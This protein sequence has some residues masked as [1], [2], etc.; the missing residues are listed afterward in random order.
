[1]FHRYHERNK[2]VIRGATKLCKKLLGFD[3]NA[4]YLC[5]LMHNMPTE[6]FVR[7]KAEEDF[8]PVQSQ[9]YGVKATEWLESEARRIGVRIIHKFNGKEKRIGSR[10]IPVD[11]F[12]TRDKHSLPISWLLLAWA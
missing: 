10:N 3:A 6:A 9:K 8:R 11:G 5:A 7:R 12:F 2:T 4:L 1:M